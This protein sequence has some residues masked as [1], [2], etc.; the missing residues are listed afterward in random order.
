LSL[1]CDLSDELAHAGISVSSSEAPAAAD[2]SPPPPA[3]EV[4]D[5]ATFLAALSRLL[6]NA[7]AASVQAAPTSVVVL[8]HPSP[9]LPD[10]VPALVAAAA[11]CLA[12]RSVVV[13]AP[14]VAPADFA[15]VASLQARQAT[16]LRR[17][18]DFPVADA[19][20]AHDQL[21][22]DKDSATTAY[23]AAT[24]DVS[25]AGGDAAARYAQ[26]L[27]RARAGV[28]A[29]AAGVGASV[30]WVDLPAGRDPDAAALDLCKELVGAT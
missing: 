24:E 25:G 12:V 14:A 4:H 1:H 26:R 10:R 6:P 7:A 3:A 27:G 23:A 29:V 21:N 28:L 22:A 18:L 16:L 2:A 20:A 8:E 15:R 9:L 30:R 11:A 5:A 13:V 19:A 17:L